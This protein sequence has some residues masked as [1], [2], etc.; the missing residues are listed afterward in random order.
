MVPMVSSGNKMYRYYLLIVRIIDHENWFQFPCLFST[1]FRKIRREGGEGVP[2]ES[3]NRMELTYA[4]RF[5]Y[6]YIL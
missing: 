5:L 3:L 6:W 1:F 4:V 2:I